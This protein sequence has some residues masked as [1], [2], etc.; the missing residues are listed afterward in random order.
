MEYEGHPVGEPS[1]R[2]DRIIWYLREQD[3]GEDMPATE[4]EEALGFEI[5]RYKNSLTNSW[6]LKMIGYRFEPGGRG[7]GNVSKFIWEG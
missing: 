4:V 3:R 5:R 7:R 1:G 2:V 6:D